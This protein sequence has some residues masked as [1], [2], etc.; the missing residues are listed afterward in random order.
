MANTHLEHLEDDIL[1]NGSAGGKNAVAFLRELGQMLTEP[2]SN[3]RITTKCDGA[4]AV[5]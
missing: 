1:N 5:V 4:P 3:I 2:S